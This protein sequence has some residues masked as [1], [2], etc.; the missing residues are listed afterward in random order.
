V[1]FPN[2]ELI[3][4]FGTSVALITLVPA[5]TPLRG[6]VEP[7]LSRYGGIND[8]NMIVVAGSTQA[9]LLAGATDAMVRFSAQGQ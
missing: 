3:V 8:L 5:V 4:V 7:P 1:L 9:S 6:C 2:R